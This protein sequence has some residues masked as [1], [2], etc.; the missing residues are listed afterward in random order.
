MTGRV[1][2]EPGE[3]LGDLLRAARS[4]KGWS[5]KGVAD[6]LSVGISAISGWEGGQT[7]PSEPLLPQV[8]SVLGIEIGR[9]QEAWAAYRRGLRDR[10]R[11]QHQQG[12]SAGQLAAI[13]GMPEDDVRAFFDLD[14][15]VE[16]AITR[17]AQALRAEVNTVRREL[18]NG[19]ITDK[20]AKAIPRPA[21]EVLAE[22]EA[23]LVKYLAL[24]RWE[25]EFARNQDAPEN[26]WR[27]LVELDC[28]CITEAL[29]DGEDHLPT[30]VRR[31]QRLGG[32]GKE[33]KEIHPTYAQTYL[34][35]NTGTRIHCKCLPPPPPLK[36]RM[37]DGEIE[38]ISGD[39][40]TWGNGNLVAHCACYPPGLL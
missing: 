4:A 40:H 23:Y 38:W 13:H 20:L 21:A 36:G 35:N 19:P 17:E 16:R 33:R 1:R 39:I 26:K 28:G 6:K 5:K 37:V 22:Y 24:N 31:N 12:Q 15:A 32:D 29:T 7:A 3:A 34:M 27:W 18:R 10:I 14:A 11:Q 9:L 25:S 8:A 30:D 2:N